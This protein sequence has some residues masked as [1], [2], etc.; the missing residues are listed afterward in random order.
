MHNFFVKFWFLIFCWCGVVRLRGVNKEL[1]Y[2]MTANP[3]CAGA[4]VAAEADWGCTVSAK[5]WG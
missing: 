2:R 3:R 4:E 1:H 5:H